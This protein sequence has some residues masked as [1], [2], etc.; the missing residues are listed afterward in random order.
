M[1]GFST[2][3]TTGHAVVVARWTFG[4]RVIGLGHGAPEGLDA[5]GSPLLPLLPLLPLEPLV[6]LLPLLVPS[7][8]AMPPPHAAAA[9]AMTT[10]RAK[11]PAA[12]RDRNMQSCVSKPGAR[13]VG[14][15]V[16][17]K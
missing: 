6:P 16:A 14:V 4:S 5:H 9:P 11:T 12:V 13:T 10:E 8:G 17:E 7:A 3:V 2:G 15:E 1:Y